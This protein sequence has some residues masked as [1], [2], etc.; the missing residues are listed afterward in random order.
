MIREIAD[1]FFGGI[2]LSVRGKKA[3]KQNLS[4]NFKSSIKLLIHT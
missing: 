1:F 3:E 2:L 4:H